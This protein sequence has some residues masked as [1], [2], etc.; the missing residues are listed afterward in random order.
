MVLD[1]W[2]GHSGWPEEQRRQLVEWYE[3]GLSML[4]DYDE[5]RVE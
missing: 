1:W 3:E 4:K 2:L 5:V